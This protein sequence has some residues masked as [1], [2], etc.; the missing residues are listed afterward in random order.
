MLD[1][2]FPMKQPQSVSLEDPSCQIDTHTFKLSVTQ[3]FCYNCEVS[4]LKWR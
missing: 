4:K 1:R 2:T 3:A